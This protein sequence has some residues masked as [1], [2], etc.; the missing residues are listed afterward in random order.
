MEEET[1]NR[2]LKIKSIDIP[3]LN[4][5]DGIS[6]INITKVAKQLGGWIEPTNGSGHFAQ[7]IFKNSTRPIPCSQDVGSGRIIGQILEQLKNFM[8]DN[9]LPKRKLL[10]EAFNFGDLQRVT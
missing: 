2:R 8:P 3:S 9:K 1:I 5:S 10:R 7:I 4:T 6:W